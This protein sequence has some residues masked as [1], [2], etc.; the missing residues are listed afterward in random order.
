MRMRRKKNL[1]TRNQN[2]KS[3][4]LS[5]STNI[6]QKKE[7]DRYELVDYSALFK[8]DNPVYLEIGCG[9]GRFVIEM[10]KNNK[11]AN[12][13]GVELLE[14]VIISA[15]EKADSEKVENVRFFNVGA[16]ILHYF[17]PKNSV[18]GIY[19]NFSCPYPKK[20]YANHRLTHERFLTV[21]KKFLKPNSF[22]KMKTDSDGLFE[23]SLNSLEENGFKIIDKTD[24]L[25]ANAPLDNI[26]T[27]YEEKFVKENKKIH[28]LTAVWEQKSEEL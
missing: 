18:S 22:I 16:E 4:V 12:Y 27:E 24:D 25:H 11:N 8:N 23:F 7:E 6:Y 15:G 13:I 17:L 26:M 2:C 28:A 9:K 3:I 5:R 19:L 1:A 20:Q 10:A 21:Y 14:N